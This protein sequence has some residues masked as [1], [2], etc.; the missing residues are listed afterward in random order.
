MGLLVP[1][2]REGR[3]LVFV[4]AGQSITIVAGLKGVLWMG[5]SPRNGQSFAAFAG[6]RCK[7]FVMTKE[8]TPEGW[9]DVEMK[10]Y[11]LADNVY[12]EPT[13][14]PTTVGMT[15]TDVF[16]VMREVAERIHAKRPTLVLSCE[17]LNR[18][19]LIV[20]GA[21]RLLGNDPDTTLEMLRESRAPRTV[22]YNPNFLAFVRDAKRV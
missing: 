21:L 3:D 16:L 1:R 10:Q 18:C 15:T 12:D 2:E 9:T 22:L 20:G 11:P 5:S 13:S 14:P 4:G 17:G 8:R 19:A 6:G 7:A